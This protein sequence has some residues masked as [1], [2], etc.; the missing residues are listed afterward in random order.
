M[1]LCVCAFLKPGM[2]RS[3]PRSSF[4]LEMRSVLPR[5]SDI[6][7]ALPVGPELAVEM[8]Q[9]PGLSMGMMRAL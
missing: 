6:G 7:N 3:P 5:A 9:S 4:A 8:E 1:G 2:T